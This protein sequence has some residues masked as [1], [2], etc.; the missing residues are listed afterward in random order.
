MFMRGFI[1]SSPDHW[2]HSSEPV[3]D[4]PAVAPRRRGGNTP[5]PELS[6]WKRREAHQKEV[7]R[8]RGEDPERH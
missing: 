8:T 6:R 1:R 4:N 7:P 5:V 2:N 3:R